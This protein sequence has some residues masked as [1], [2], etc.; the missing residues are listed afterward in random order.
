VCSIPGAFTSSLRLFST[1]GALLFQFT[2]VFAEPLGY[3]TRPGATH[4]HTGGNFTSL[5]PYQVP[6]RAPLVT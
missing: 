3:V 6:V 1:V 4:S 2:I 5:S